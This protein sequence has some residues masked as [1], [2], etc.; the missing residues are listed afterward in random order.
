MIAVPTTERALVSR[1]SAE[2]FRY[3]AGIV[4]SQKRASTV[5]PEAKSAKAP[6]M[7]CVSMALATK[8]FHLSTV[9]N[10]SRCCRSVDDPAME[11]QN[12]LVALIRRHALHHAAEDEIYGQWIMEELAR[13]GYWLSPGTLYPMLH[14]MEK[15]G[16]LRSREMEMGRA[17]RQLS[18]ATQRRKGL[19]RRSGQAARDRGRIDRAKLREGK[20]WQLVRI[21]VRPNR[22]RA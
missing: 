8:R 9:D 22:G 13:H 6:M 21:S 12:L 2:H 10:D 17:A 19:S 20:T 16:Y 1:K 18:R 7:T 14:G 11:H 15:K 5:R 3:Q 4:P